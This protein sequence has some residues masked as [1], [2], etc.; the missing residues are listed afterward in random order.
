MLAKHESLPRSP[1]MPNGPYRFYSAEAIANRRKVGAL[2]RAARKLVQGGTAKRHTEVEPAFP[3]WLLR[4][5]SPPS[6]L[7]QP[8]TTSRSGASFSGG[9]AF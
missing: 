3:E 8:S 1:A 9:I 4:Y 5:S 7:H 6:G 2:L